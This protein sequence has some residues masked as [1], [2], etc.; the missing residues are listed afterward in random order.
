MKKWNANQVSPALNRGGVTGS[1]ISSGNNKKPTA[2][3]KA[4]ADNL[5]RRATHSLSESDE[6]QRIVAE[7]MVAHEKQRKA[8]KFTPSS[9][10]LNPHLLAAIIAVLLTLSTVLWVGCQAASAVYSVVGVHTTAIS[11]AL[12]E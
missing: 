2:S 7:C 1:P 5:R 6:Y 12:S 3:T 10:V 11:R 4:F 9:F 8:S